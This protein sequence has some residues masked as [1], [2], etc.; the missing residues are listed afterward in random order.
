VSYTI[1]VGTMIGSGIQVGSDGARLTIAGDPETWSEREKVRILFVSANPKD[2]NLLELIKECN[3]VRDRVISTEYGDQFDFDQRHEVSVSEMD[4]HVLDYK[5]Q[6]LHFSGH[7]SSDG[8]IIFQ[9]SD[10]E[11]EGTSIEALSD[12]FR[13]VNEDENMTDDTRIRLVFLN[14]CY[15]QKQAKAI[16]KHVDCVIGMSTSV[17]DEAA[18][19]FAESFYQALG[20]GKSIKTAFDLGCNKVARLNIPEAHTPKLLYKPDVDPSSIYLVRSG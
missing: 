5:P 16:S 20:Y 3:N 14:A 4:R 15:S 17:T 12:L 10:K 19:V 9:D 18:R 1:K 8:I 13:I 11:S 6:V 7:G 2:T